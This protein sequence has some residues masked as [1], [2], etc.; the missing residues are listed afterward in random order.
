MDALITLSH[1]SR[2]PRASAGI[3]ELTRAAG[4]ELGVTAVAAH[5]EFDTPDL[6]G[7]ARQLAAAGH[8][9]A[10][11]VPLLFTRAFH[12]TVDV[13]AA[14]DA[15]REASGVELVAAEG[16]GQGEDIAE[17]LAARVRRDAPH[18]SRIVLYPVGTSNEKAAQ[19][20]VA[21][22][23]GVEKQAGT[24]VTTVP[25][26]GYGERVGSSGVAEVASASA[27]LLPLFVTE[28]LL[29]DRVFRMWPGTTSAP[30]GA[31]LSPIVAA[32][33]RAAHPSSHAK[34]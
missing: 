32:R 14:L 6:T 27:H 2:H 33:Y 30:L 26:T 11:V 15:A 13:P 17:L 21:L 8:T 10:V 9:R 19:K 24:P 3:D 22:G 18:A 20:T 34:V 28:G 5:L 16:L 29:L 4:R 25:A 7:A 31:D 12:A 1:G 23:V